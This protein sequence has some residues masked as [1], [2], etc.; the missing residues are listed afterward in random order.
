MTSVSNDKNCDVSEDESDDDD[1]IAAVHVDDKLELDGR[2]GDD[3]NDDGDDD[4]DDDSSRLKSWFAGIKRN[5]LKRARKLIGVLR[6]SDQRREGFR[7]FI[8]TGNERGW[9]FS[10]TE[11]G[12]R[13]QIE[14]PELQ[15]L[16]DVKTR[17]DSV[18]MMLQRLRVL[19]P[20]G[21]S[22]RLN[23]YSGG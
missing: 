20:V 12:E 23:G 11:T 17:W 22:Q 15:L 13:L 18:Y 1:I 7:R 16:R 2:F 3:G 21:L 9:F 14:L 4:G 10:K 5:P 19:R 6:A 8:Q